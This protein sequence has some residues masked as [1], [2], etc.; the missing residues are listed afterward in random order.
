MIANIIFKIV[1]IEQPRKIIIRKII[2]TLFIAIY[3]PVHTGD[4][5][6]VI[7]GIGWV[8]TGVIII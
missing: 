4:I 3:T 2:T 8:G 7:T 5:T 1:R 6:V